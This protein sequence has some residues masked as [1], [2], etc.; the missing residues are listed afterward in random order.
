MVHEKRMNLLKFRG[1]MALTQDVISSRIGVNRQYYAAVERGRINGNPDF[2]AKLQK[3]FD[4][5]DSE[6]Y[7]L[8]KIEER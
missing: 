1:A 6:M 7:P 5:P 8:Q 3:A 2:W 4:I